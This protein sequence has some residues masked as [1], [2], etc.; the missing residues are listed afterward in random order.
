MQAKQQ[1][2]GPALPPR[3]RRAEGAGGAAR[4][5]EHSHRNVLEVRE[6]G[7]HRPTT[8]IARSVANPQKG[9]FMPPGRPGMPWVSLPIFS[10]EVSS[11]LRTAALNAA[12]TRSSSMS[13]SSAS[14]LGSMVMR[15]TSCLHVITTFTRP[16]PDSP[17][18]SMKASSSCAFLR[19][20]CI[21]WA[22]FMRPASCPL[23]NMVWFPLL[24]FWLID[25]HEGTEIRSPRY[26]VLCCAMSA[27]V[28]TGTRQS[29]ALVELALPGHRVRPPPAKQERGKA[30]KAT[31][32]A[33]HL[34]QA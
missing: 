11:A 2:C 28:E 14:R 13:L 23:L 19:L 30:P 18:T 15:L 3:P 12:A 20:S 17:S 25:S 6:D 5:T 10:E 4:R 32:G 8:Q 24:S 16:A 26:T 7:E 9:N 33:L 34:T 22:C 1:A 31:Q 27:A 29:S 21:A